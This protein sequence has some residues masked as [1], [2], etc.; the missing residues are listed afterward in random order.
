MN[1]NTLITPAFEKEDIQ[2]MFSKE[3][4]YKAG[5]T[6]RT[7]FITVDPAAG[8]QGSKFAVTSCFYEDHRMVVKNFFLF[9]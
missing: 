7:V 3:R 2:K 1:V 9:I 5:K 8:G 6:Q 4:I